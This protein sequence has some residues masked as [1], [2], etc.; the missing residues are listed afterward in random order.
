MSNRN[1]IGHTTILKQKTTHNTEIINTW[2]TKLRQTAKLMIA[3]AGYIASLAK[4]PHNAEH[5]RYVALA[6]GPLFENISHTHLTTAH[7][8][9]LDTNKSTSGLEAIQS[10]FRMLLQ[11]LSM[12]RGDMW[13]TFSTAHSASVQVKIRTQKPYSHVRCLKHNIF[14]C[15]IV[16]IYEIVSRVVKHILKRSHFCAKTVFIIAQTESWQFCIDA[17]SAT[18][19]CLCS[20]GDGWL[21]VEAV[22]C[23]NALWWW[24]E[25]DDDPRGEIPA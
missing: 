1:N 17:S 24:C 8:Y 25:V 13:R 16:W 19:V 7:I 5:N 4:L 6:G 14:K 21:V 9:F 11:R 23:R 22:V 12:P 10:R 18:L 20:P 3:M 15:F 2:P